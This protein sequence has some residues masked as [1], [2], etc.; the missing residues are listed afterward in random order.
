MATHLMVYDL[1]EGK[2]INIMFENTKEGVTQ[3][4]VTRWARA[5]IAC[6]VVFYLIT[7][8][9]DRSLQ[10]IPAIAHHSDR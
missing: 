10:F 1:C 2:L 5:Y 3:Q 9:K 6:Q 8:F 4:S 7:L